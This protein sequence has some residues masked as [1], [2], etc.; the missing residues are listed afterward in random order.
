MAFCGG[1]FDAFLLNWPCALFLI[2]SN[3]LYDTYH[4]VYRVL[5]YLL[6]YGYHFM[7][8]HHWAV[9]SAYVSAAALLEIS[10][11]TSWML[12]MSSVNNAIASVLD[13]V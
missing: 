12:E 3:I 4:R 5:V 11:H 7:L 6:C 9:C 2:L 10:S 13:I 1:G 8:F